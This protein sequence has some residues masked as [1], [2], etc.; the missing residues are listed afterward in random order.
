MSNSLAATSGT[1]NVCQRRRVESV[2]KLCWCGA[3]I[4]ALISKSATNPYRRYYRCAY[5][6]GHKVM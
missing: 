5:A 4:S 3:S 2:P 6:A 1:S